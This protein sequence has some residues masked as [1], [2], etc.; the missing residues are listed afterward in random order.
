MPFLRFTRDKRGYENTYIMHAVRRRGK[1]RPRILYWF[2]TPPNVKVG[3]AAI[4][5]D[6]IR[7]MEET[8]PNLAFDWTKIFEAQPAP[9]PA[10]EPHKDRRRR[11]G[12][13]SGQPPG[14]ERRPAA[15]SRAAAAQPRT[16]EPSVEP[17]VEPEF[18]PEQISPE[19]LA[20]AVPAPPEP[21]ERPAGGAL[22]E[23]IVGAETLARLRARY[24]EVLARIT[25]RGGGPER[26]EALRAH[27]ERL[28]PDA[29]VTA[30][31]ARRGLDEFEA[32]FDALRAAIGGRRRRRSR[33]GGA[34]RSRR[35]RELAQQAA[36]RGKSVSESPE[37]TPDSEEEPEGPAGDEGEPE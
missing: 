33:R 29:W 3:R 37:S 17:P 36:A 5:E 18:P 22:V 19:E 14:R 25:E 21:V 32:T 7:S 26:V 28:N 12:E 27:A 23:E 9:A 16:I 15:S 35:R 10:P 6:A 30:E 13:G 20:V 2:R 4:D 8:H 1:N 31:E 34:R 11:R 24:A